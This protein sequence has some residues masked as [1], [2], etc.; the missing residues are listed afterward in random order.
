MYGLI[1]KALKTMIL[2][3][4]GEEVWN[5]ILQSSEVSE[6]SFLSMQ[7]YDDSVTYALVGATSEVLKASP[8]QCLELFGH[9]WATV[10]APEAYG[11]LMD[12]TG[13]DLIGF[14]ENVNSLHDRI[15]STF[16]GYIPPYFSV[17]TN[18]D[19]VSLRYES[20]REGL[21]PFVIGV[22]KGLAENFGQQV[23]FSSVEKCPVDAGET[24][25]INF[26]VSQK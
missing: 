24:S 11:M 25:L 2:S 19:E 13:K 21:T 26:T 1:N 18:S 16:V 22:V 15:T 17:S 10:T 12:S 5:Q 6:D 8:E 9:Y 23:S 7:R 4:Q 3:S 20:T 14:L